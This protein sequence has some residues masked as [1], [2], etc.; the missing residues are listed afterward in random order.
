MDQKISQTSIP[1]LLALTSSDAPAPGGGGIAALTGALGSA[2]G[3]MVLALSYEKKSYSNLDEDIQQQL[4]A[5]DAEL[6]KLQVRLSEL[7][8][9]DAEAF[10]GFIDAL[11]LPKSTDAEKKARRE[12]LN[13]AAIYAMQIPMETAECCYRVLQQLPVIAEYGNK[14]VITDAGIA[15]LLANASVEA[16]LLNVKINLPSIKTDDIREKAA[17]RL[18]ELLEA[19]PQLHKKSIDLVYSRIE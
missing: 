14:N 18:Q 6:G 16:A 15:S 1:Q 8:D 19:A 4:K 10:T 17:V 12:A 5:A 3:Q 13:N 11:Q 7:I 2:L 9:L